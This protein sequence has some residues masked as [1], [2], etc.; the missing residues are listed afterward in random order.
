MVSKVSAKAYCQKNSLTISL[1]LHLV[2]VFIP[3][4]LSKEMDSCKVGPQSS[5]RTSLPQLD[6]KGMNCETI[7]SS[8]L[9]DEG[10]SYVNK[11]S[12]TKAKENEDIKGFAGIER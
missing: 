4:R 8:S 11:G 2:H 6:I 1:A 9:V 3:V 12:K 10:T 5:R 7:V